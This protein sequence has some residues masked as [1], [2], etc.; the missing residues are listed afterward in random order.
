MFNGNGN[1]I[2]ESY[3]LKDKKQLIQNIILNNGNDILYDVKTLYA[4]NNQPP[5]FTLPR[6][7]IV[8]KHSFEILSVCDE[9]ERFVIHPHVKLQ[10]TKNGG[11]VKLLRLEKGYEIKNHFVSKKKGISGE[12]AVEVAGTGVKLAIDN[13]RES[14]FRTHLDKLTHEHLVLI[15]DS[16]REYSMGGLLSKPDSANIII[17]F[18][19]IDKNDESDLSD[20]IRYE[21]RRMK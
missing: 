14:E 17:D 13:S 20:A 21:R 2:L 16:I 6:K 5:R 8:D 10:P 9:R 12:G 15:I 7:R 4:G 3:F 11:T 18:I 1:G 19:T